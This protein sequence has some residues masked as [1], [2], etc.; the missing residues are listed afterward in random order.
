[1]K[2]LSLLGLMH[3]FQEDKIRDA[4]LQK[5]PRVL[6]DVQS[7]PGDR[8]LVALLCDYVIDVGFITESESTNL[9]N[10]GSPVDDSVETR[11]GSI[12]L[13]SLQ[14]TSGSPTPPDIASA[15]PSTSVPENHLVSPSSIVK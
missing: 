11:A 7:K 1:M 3:A 8:G 15:G 2:P 6:S 9:L 12:P 14:I 5:Y 10:P 4:Y 13:V